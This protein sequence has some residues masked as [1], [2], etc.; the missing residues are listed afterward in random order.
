MRAGRSQP[1]RHRV[2][3]RNAASG[4]TRAAHCCLILLA[5]LTQLLAPAQRGHAPG[6][7]SHS[8]IFATAATGSSLT[9]ASIS[10]EKSAVGCAYH[11]SSHDG[12]GP[13]PGDRDNCPCCPCPCC[14]SPVH[15]ALGIVPQE[16][17]RPAYAPRLF[18]SVAPPALLGTFTRSA[19]FAGQPR[20]PP[21]LI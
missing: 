6:F 12:N 17:A 3:T 2:F 16:T 7:A 20:A 18:E 4:W 9:P 15:A 13:V 11:A 1:P 19:A 8:T 21:I 14:C 10:G 5:C